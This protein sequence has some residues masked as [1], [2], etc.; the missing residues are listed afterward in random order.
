[1]NDF[2]KEELQNLFFYVQV[3][4]SY[5]R[6]DGYNALMEKIQFMIDNYCEHDYHPVLGSFQIESCH[7]CMKVK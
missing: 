4:P 3:V 7:K 1:M 2:T 5:H 6:R